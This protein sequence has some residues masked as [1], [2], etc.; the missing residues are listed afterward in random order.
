MRVLAR[1]AKVPPG[2]WVGTGI[3]GTS[4]AVTREATEVVGSEVGG[5]FGIFGDG[6]VVTLLI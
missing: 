6:D 4:D 3:A 5:Y 2:P 1:T